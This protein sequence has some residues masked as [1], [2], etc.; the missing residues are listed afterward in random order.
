MG[1]RGDGNVSV[2][3]LLSPLSTKVQNVHGKEQI[4]ATKSG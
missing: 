1:V 3:D 4:R 2:S